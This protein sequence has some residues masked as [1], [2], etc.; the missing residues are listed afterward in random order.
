M[1][2][3]MEMERK[4]SSNTFRKRA[5]VKRFLFSTEGTVFSQNSNFIR[6]FIKNRDALGDIIYV[7]NK[8]IKIVRVT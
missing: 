7:P 8:Y 1:Q 5:C 3:W 6:L 2:W 4:S